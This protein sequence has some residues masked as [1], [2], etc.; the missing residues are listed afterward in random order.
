MRTNAGAGAEV[1]TGLTDKQLA[2]AYERAFEAK[3]VGNNLDAMLDSYS[4]AGAAG[5]RAVADLAITAQEAECA[6]LRRELEAER[7]K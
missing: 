3:F 4:G 1:T 7:A 5:L 2:D 6:G